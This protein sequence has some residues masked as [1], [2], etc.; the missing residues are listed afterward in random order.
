MSL[1]HS[2]HRLAAMTVIPAQAGKES[3]FVF[4][5]TAVWMPV[6]TVMTM[7][8]Q[9]KWLLRHSLQSGRGERIRSMNALNLAFRSCPTREI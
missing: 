6:S 7:T 9:P 1:S 4:H 3:S 2:R 5:S 8:V